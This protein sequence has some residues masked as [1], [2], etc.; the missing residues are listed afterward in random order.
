MKDFTLFLPTLSPAISLFIDV[1]DGK[2]KLVELMD[3]KFMLY[4]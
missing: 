1:S 4:L 3:Q 2:V